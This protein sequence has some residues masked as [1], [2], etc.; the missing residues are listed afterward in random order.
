MRATSETGG[1]NRR[2]PFHL[3]SIHYSVAAASRRS[4]RRYPRNP[5]QCVTGIGGF[6]FR[7]KNPT[8]LG[9]WYKDNLGID[10]VPADYNQK[11]WSQE[12]GP[13]V[14]A[15]FPNDSDYFGHADRGWMIISAFG[16]LTPWWSSCVLPRLTSL[17]IRR[18]IRTDGLLV[19][20]IRKEIQ[21][22]YGNRNENG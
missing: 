4:P 21:S 16:S 15:P 8:A 3:L 7:A 12:A 18:F 11:P 1:A 6:I 17:W 22:S 20:V 13:T 14:F 19:C 9:Q 5:M 10:L 2:Q